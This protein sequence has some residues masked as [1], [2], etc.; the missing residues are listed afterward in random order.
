M[1]RY[2]METKLAYVLSRSIEAVIHSDP[3]NPTWTLLLKLEPL[4]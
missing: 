2:R 3:T 4:A 1:W